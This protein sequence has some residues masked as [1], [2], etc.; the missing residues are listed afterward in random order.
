MT[1]DPDRLECIIFDLDGLLVDSE[2]LQYQS[3]VQANILSPLGL[4]STRPY[5]PEAMRGEALAIG[6][7]GIGR[8]GTRKPIKAFFTRGITPAAL[9]ILLIHLPQRQ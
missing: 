4:S 5:Y 6:Y 7:T 3:Y 1:P 9:S 2:P 8:S